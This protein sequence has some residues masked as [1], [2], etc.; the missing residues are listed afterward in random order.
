MLY[1]KSQINNY[2]SFNLMIQQSFL[3][4][5]KHIRYKLNTQFIICFCLKAIINNQFEI[6]KCFG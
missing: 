5:V 4:E 1:K 6:F 3:T 2:S